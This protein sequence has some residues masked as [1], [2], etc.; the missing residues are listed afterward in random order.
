LRECINSYENFLNYLRDTNNNIDYTYLWDII[1]APNKKLFPEGINL[2]I[3]ELVNDDI[4]DNIKLICPTNHYSNE[5]FDVNKKTLFL[6]KLDNYFEPIYILEDVETKYN[7]TKLFSLQNQNI[8]PSI[9]NV[10]EFVKST[11]NTKC[12]PLPSLPKIYDFKRNIVLD[13]LVNYLNGE[14]YK[15][16][17]QVL[18]YNSKV[19]GVVAKYENKVGF[20]PCYPSSLMLDIENDFKWMDDDNIWNNYKDTI[21]FLTKLKKKNKNIPCS[22]KIKVLE[23]GLIVGILTETNQFI[24]LSEPEQDVYGDDYP[25]IN[26][27]N[28]LVVDK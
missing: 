1:C 3:F 15:V 27:E 6:M 26:N 2:V 21:D 24:S 28:Y 11:L 13:K 10:L 23:D 16:I 7:V 22:P 19:I 5:F 9:K 4:T 14:N 8:L 17:N 25:S 12:S 18:N 20:I